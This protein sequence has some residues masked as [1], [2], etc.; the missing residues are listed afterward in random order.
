MW[1]STQRTNKRLAG[2][3]LLVDT[4]QEQMGVAKSATGV[5]FVKSSPLFRFSAGCNAGSVGWVSG[6]AMPTL[7]VNVANVAP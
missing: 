2:Y 7:S 1:D 5:E 4:T 3:T 6:N